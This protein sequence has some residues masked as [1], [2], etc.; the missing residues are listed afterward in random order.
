MEYFGTVVR[1][2]RGRDRYRV[3]AVIGTDGEDLTVADGGLH[4]V[5]SPKRKNLR[6]VEVIGHMTDA[7]EKRLRE[8]LTDET[9]REIIT[10][11]DKRK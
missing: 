2:T 6:H 4:K 7:E 1:S 3:F 8:S 5:A 10:S 9:V 11:Y